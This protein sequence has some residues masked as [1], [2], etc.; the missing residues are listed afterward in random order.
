MKLWQKTALTACAVLVLAVSV[1][2]GLYLY[3]TR[4]SML[5]VSCQRLEERC[6]FREESFLEKYNK[7]RT[8]SQS[9]Q[10]Q[11]IWLHYCASQ[12]KDKS[13]VL[14]YQQ[15]TVYSDKCFEA[16]K[17]LH[18]PKL[19]GWNCFT[20]TQQGREYLFVGKPVDGVNQTELYV[21]EDVTDLFDNLTMLF[22]RSLVLAAAAI[23]GGVWLIGWLTRRNMLPLMRLQEAAQQIAQGNYSQRTMLE[24]KDE[25]G[26]LSSSFDTMA[27]SVEHTV[28]ELT[29]SNQ[30]QKR[31]ISAVTHEF[32]TPLSGML[33]N[34]ELLLNLKLSETECT[35]SLLRIQRE[36][37]R[38]ERMVQKLL[39]LIT[40]EQTP[41]LRKTD[42]PALLERVADTL[43]SKYPS[44]QI[45]TEC[46][47]DWMLL[48]PDLM[49]SV[50]LN[51]ADN[52]CKA[53][54]PGMTVKLTAEK[55][56]FTVTD[57]GCGI[58]EADLDKVKEPF[59]VADKSRSKKQG[60]T[61]LGLSLAEEIV[62]VHGGTLTIESALGQGTTVKVMLNGNHSVMGQ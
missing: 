58:A 14:L 33:I 36:A 13:A 6:S 52:A 34:T 7:R 40:L 46:G 17:T 39:K 31:F 28:Q 29:R 11:K 10:L 37:L 15:E 25:I 51:L 27:D 54:Q 50:L 47:V 24:S 5:T 41:E 44:L 43:Q 9:E 1:L 45:Q 8:D 56:G 35:E 23:G 26:T 48:N 49:E 16:G 20:V 59:Y 38:L 61:G 3:Q 21:Y 2:S 57:T 42:V 60:G 55:S 62:K 18:L 22:W 53:S 19:D 32:K 4:T 30:R 12:L